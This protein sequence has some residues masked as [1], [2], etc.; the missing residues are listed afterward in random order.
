MFFVKKW[1]FFHLLSF[2]KIGQKKVLGDILERKNAFLDYKKKK[3][4][5]QKISLFQKGLFHGFGQK[6][7][8][9]HL[10]ISCKILKKEVFSDILERRRFRFFLEAGGLQHRQYR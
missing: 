4:K 2:G 6:M 7:R 5:N 8:F 10:F 9:F 3:E 1:D